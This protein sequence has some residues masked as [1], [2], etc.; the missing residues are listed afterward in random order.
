ML[1]STEYLMEMQK[2]KFKY[3]VKAEQGELTYEDMIKSLKEQKEDFLYWKKLQEEE[4]RKPALTPKEEQQL[5]EEIGK[6][7]DKIIKSLNI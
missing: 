1:N 6:T 4:Q 7:V 3:L 5:T 2:K